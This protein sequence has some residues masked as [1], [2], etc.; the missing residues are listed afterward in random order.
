MDI[1]EYLKNMP[2][3]RRE[4]ALVVQKLILDLFPAVQ[5][6]LKYKMPTYESED[7][8]IAIANQKN[9]WSVY[10]CDQSKISDY[11]SRHPEIKHGKGC[12]NFKKTD[13]VDIDA[14]KVVIQK[15]L[16]K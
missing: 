7:G 5:I 12:L 8:W 6:S 2:E 11:L 13:E 14:M 1:T 4:K 15:A 10:T 9:Y 16:A 3:E